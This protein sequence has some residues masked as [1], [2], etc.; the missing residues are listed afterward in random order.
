MITIKRED[1][2]KQHPLKRQ[3]SWKEYQ[4]PFS[5]RKLQQQGARCLD[6][7]TPFCS[8]GSF[9]TGSFGCP[10]YNLIPEW[11][12]L[13]TRGK[14]REA[15]DRLMLTNNFPEFTGRVC[16]APCE[17][18]C[19]MALHD[20]AVAIK[21]IEQAII[22][23]GFAEGWIVPQPPKKRT[24]KRVA[25]VGS[26][27]AGLAAA[28]Q[29]NKVG[30]TVV[31]FEKADRIGGLLVYGI[32]NMKLEKRI[33]ERRI[34]VLEAEGISFVTNTELGKDVTLEQLQADY[35]AV[36]LCTGAQKQRLLTV[37]G[38]HL[39]GVYEAMDY[40][41]QATKALLDHTQPSISATGKDVIV[42]GGGDT[43]ADCVATALRQQC[44]SV[45]QFGRHPQLPKERTA[46]NPWPEF[47]YVFTVDYAYE[48]AIATF[49]RDPRQYS[50]LTKKIVGDERG[51]VTE[52]H[53]V[54][55]QVIRK[56]DGRVIIE[57]RP[58]T[59]K[60]WAADL[61]FIAIGFSGTDDKLLADCG[62]AQQN[63]LVQAEYGVY[64]TNISGVFAAGDMRRG[65]SLI[66]W[67][68]HEG[69]EVARECDRF[70]MGET[71]L[72]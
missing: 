2:K 71:M 20:D 33:V 53:T 34:K 31:V 25:I 32:P 18:S 69:R 36:I 43:G 46:D 68:I 51:H 55:A 1:P 47:P 37:E 5:E 8:T 3:Q 10:L 21:S 65:Q 13:V 27:P 61:I 54:E 60:V 41:T 44:R 26:G 14:W 16:P 67:A 35:D 62:L 52:V 63:G 64:T 66:V 50:I 29:L 11:N 23:K 45:V 40:L 72:M 56:N 12:E 58:G 7:G 28:D 17:G 6:C 38:V 39:D 48:E 59:E 30:H 57:E 42:I 22:D 9:A 70:L 4:L 49:Q 24:G 19:T 15:L